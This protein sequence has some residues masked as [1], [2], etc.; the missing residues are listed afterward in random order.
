MPP[1]CVILHHLRNSSDASLLAARHFMRGDMPNLKFSHRR[2]FLRLAAGT[3]ASP[4]ISRIACAQAYPVRPVRFLVGA[5]A[6]GAL[7]IVARVMGQWL[8]ERLAQAFVIEN[9]V[10]AA[11]IIAF[12]AIARAPAD[13]YT[14]AL[15]PVSMAINPSVYQK[16]NYDFVRDMAPVASLVRVPLVLEVN[17]L[18]PLRTVPELIAYAKINPGKLNMASAG[19]GTSSHLAGELFKMMSGVDLV[20]VP[21]RGGAPAL[22]DLVGGQVQ[23]MFDI[24]ASSVET[25]LAG[26]LRALAVTTAGRSEALPSIPTMAE[27]LPGYEAST[28]FGVGAPKNTPAEIVE[29]LNT[30][31]NAGLS[32]PKIKVR[33]ADLGA[34]VFAGSPADFGRHVADETDKWARVATFAGIKPE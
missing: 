6:G 20:H 1:A 9:R 17:P 33:L 21:Y 3:A 15:I 4:V 22:T 11:S 19:S 16:L 18:L 28:W 29:R 26:K 31:I 34:N 13:G 10:G 5:P 14:I 12:E 24:V 23:L 30:E 8:A 25:I 27:F 2:Q 32:D 7:D